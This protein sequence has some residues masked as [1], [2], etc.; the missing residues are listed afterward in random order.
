VVS[1]ALIDEGR[2]AT[3]EPEIFPSV[4]RTF[5]EVRCHFKM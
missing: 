1:L 5:C 4:A 3:F 2:I